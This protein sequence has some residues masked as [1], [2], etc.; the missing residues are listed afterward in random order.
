[1]SGVRTLSFT[2]HCLSLR[3]PLINKTQLYDLQADPHKMTDLADKHEFNV[4]NTACLLCVA[5]VD[6]D[7]EKTHAGPSHPQKTFPSTPMMI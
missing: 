1:M 4:T 6:H 2:A 7:A 3:Y 5:L